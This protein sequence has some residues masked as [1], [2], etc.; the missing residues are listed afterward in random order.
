MNTLQRRFAILTVVIF[1]FG[2]L[3]GQAQSPADELARKAQR[4][5]EA[6]DQ[7]RFAEAIALWEELTAALPEVWG[8]KMNLGLAYYLSGQP[9]RAVVPLRE[10]VGGDPSLQTGFLFLG[11]SLLET[12]KAADA[13]S[14]LEAF[15]KVNPKEP[16]GLQLLGEAYLQ[17]GKPAAALPLLLQTTQLAPDSPRGWHNLGRTYESL[18]GKAF[19][20]LESSASESAYWLAL[21]AD[22][23]VAQQQFSSAFFFYREALKK[24]PDMRGIHVAISRI[25]REKGN[26]E[27][28]AKEEAQ[29]LLLGIP[30][31]TKE[32]LVC[33][34]LEG[35]LGD[36]LRESLKEDTPESLYWRT[37]AANH[38]A[39]EAFS[40]L[41]SLPPSFEVHEL[42][43]E[44][45]RNQGRHWES[46]SEWKKALELVP[47]HPQA[48]REL[49]LSLYLNR[50]YDSA[51]SLV[52]ELLTEEPGSAQ[53]NFLAGDILLY[54][55]L[56]EASIPFLEKAVQ[57][58]PSFL[59]AHSSLGRAYMFL[60]D[61]E[62]AIPHLKAALSQDEDGSL[63]YQL[64]RAYQRTGQR[65][66]A[67]TMMA[68]YQTIRKQISE[69][70]EKLEEEVQITPPEE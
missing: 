59:G 13:V 45:H 39:L 30:D 52:D 61:A 44:I 36:V 53:L 37:K 5:S 4:A 63:R 24:K 21:I 56:V 65:D 31:C 38:L 70:E 42:K 60:A 54:E 11:A 50:D 69:Q 17:S 68:E 28:A 47:N 41:M 62:Q 9:D 20:E 67:R 14:P 19:Q 6:M 51:K 66:L 34:F 1:L 23:R 46:V 10:A 7:G 58:D 40:R 29:E 22:S 35:R 16:Q 27:W 48:R 15:R 12:G 26:N 25:Y 33:A 3:S 55:Q 18:A 57:A 8:L 49:A 64:A 32:T 2:P 43:A